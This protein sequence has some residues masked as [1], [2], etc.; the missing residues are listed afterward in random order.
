MRRIEVRSVLSFI[1]K[2]ST[3]LFSVLMVY[4]SV[5]KKMVFPLIWGSLLRMETGISQSKPSK[6]K[7]KGK[8]DLSK[9]N[10]AFI[11]IEMMVHSY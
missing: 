9:N 2:L 5:L 6:L 10:N 1:Q 3:S 8:N 11:L 4:V 7:G